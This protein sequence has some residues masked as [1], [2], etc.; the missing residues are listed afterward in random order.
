MSEEVSDETSLKM[1]RKVGPGISQEQVEK[2]MYLMKNASKDLSYEDIDTFRLRLRHEDDT[3]EGALKQLREDVTAVNP[4]VSTSVYF[5]V[6]ESTFRE[7]RV[8]RVL[9]GFSKRVP[10]CDMDYMTIGQLNQYIAHRMNSRRVR[11]RLRIV[12]DYENWKGY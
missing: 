12:Y 2:I 9:K 6:V 8:S 4:F 1:P 11:E 3:L 5:D 7:L 10:L